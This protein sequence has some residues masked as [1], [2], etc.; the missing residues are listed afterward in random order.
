MNKKFPI[1][2]FL[3]LAF[4]FNG[5]F[6]TTRR[7]PHT[8]APG[9]ISANSSYMWLKPSDADA[10]DTP[11]E[12]IGAEIR[13]GLAEGLDIGLGRTFDITEDVD[14]GEG[15]DCYWFDAKVQFNNRNNIIGKGTFSASYGFGR[16]VADDMEEYWM[17]SLVL[18]A[19]TK[20]EKSTFYMSF[21]YELPKDSQ[22]LLPFW[23]LDEES[24]NVQKAIIFGIEYKLNEKIKP[25][26][27]IGRFYYDDIG[28]GINVLTGGVNYYLE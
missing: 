13:Y 9:K 5:C 24:E 8:L 21:R 11:A 16:F 12:M 10:S 15:M 20:D 23:V 27:E 26:A 7:G 6:T 4:V 1:L 14:Q 17:N 19:G 18:L 3:L 22:E 28:D 25:V 2:A